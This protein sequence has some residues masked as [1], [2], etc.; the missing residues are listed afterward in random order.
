MTA[1]IIALFLLAFGGCVLAT[2]CYFTDDTPSQAAKAGL[3]LFAIGAAITLVV[4]AFVAVDSK[5]KT[6]RCQREAA[7][8]GLDYDWSYRNGCR[9]ELPT[10]QLVPS[11]KIRITTDGQIVTGAED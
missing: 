1:V 5:F 8:Y 9:I 6:D 10:G 7:G 11:D 3:T 2:A 4:W